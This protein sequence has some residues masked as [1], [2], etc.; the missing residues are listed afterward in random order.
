M[1]EKNQ[2]RSQDESF[3]P[4]CADL[5]K[6]YKRKVVYLNLNWNSE[7]YSGTISI[8]LKNESLLESF[9]YETA[10]FISILLWADVT[11]QVGHSMD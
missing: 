1:F 2:M 3:C 9:P 8:V 5:T 7:K 11:R 10:I 4:L 6:K